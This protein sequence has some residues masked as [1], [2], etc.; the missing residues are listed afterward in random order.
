M[1]ATTNGWGELQ[2]RKE[3]CKKKKKSEIEYLGSKSTFH[4]RKLLHKLNSQLEMAEKKSEVH[5]PLWF[6][7]IIIIC[8]DVL[9]YKHE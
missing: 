4:M 7:I 9:K 3:K 6:I 2:Q 8:T 1:K 5:L